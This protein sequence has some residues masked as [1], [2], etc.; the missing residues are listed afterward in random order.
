MSQIL[1]PRR[2]FFRHSAQ[3]SYHQYIVRA[4]VLG[5]A[6]VRATALGPHLLVHLDGA[7]RAQREARYVNEPPRDRVAGCHPSGCSESSVIRSACE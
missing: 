7:A 4:T 2:L 3:R 5:R 6:T 1:S